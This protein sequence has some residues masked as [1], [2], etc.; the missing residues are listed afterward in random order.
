MTEEGSGKMYAPSSAANNPATW[1]ALECAVV[2]PRLAD[3]AAEWT[4]VAEVRIVLGP[5]GVKLRISILPRRLRDRQSLSAE[6]QEFHQ[7]IR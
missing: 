4:E 5:Q 6:K 2:N 3:Q 7:C 1:V